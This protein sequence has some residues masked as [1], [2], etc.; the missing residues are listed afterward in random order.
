MKR[1]RRPRG[2]VYERAD[3]P[4]LWIS[5]SVNGRKIRENTHQRNER[6]AGKLLQKRLNEVQKGEIITFDAH[7]TTVEQLADMLLR[8]YRINGRKSLDTVER[9]WLVHLRPF[10]GILR[11]DQVSVDGISRYIDMRKQAGAQNGTI[12]RE[13]AALR[14]MLILG[15]RSERVVR[16]PQIP[17]LEETSPRTGFV[18]ATARDKL[19][20]EC[21][22]VGVWMRAL[23][24]CGVTFGWRV[25]ELLNLRVSQV[26]LADRTIRLNP[27]ETKNGQGRLAV[28]TDAAYVLIR[29]CVRGKAADDYVFTRNRKRIRSFRGTWAKVTEKA[30]VPALLFHDLRRSAVRSMVRSGIPERVAMT[31]SGHRTRSVFDRYN[32]VSEGDLREAARKMNPPAQAETQL[33]HDSVKVV[34]SPSLS[35]VN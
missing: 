6:Y 28:L 13:L 35:A 2:S 5:Y 17:K 15:K 23:F 10:F 14:R 19:A 4:Y 25:S 9:R 20:T 24:E 7:K 32:I 31:I 8:D 22:S 16:V 11:A 33:S 26:D 30:G 27:G 29:E 34:P 3:S 18:E 21:A 1:V 12:N